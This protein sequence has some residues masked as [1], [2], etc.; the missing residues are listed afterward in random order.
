MK[1]K[2]RQWLNVSN[3]KLRYAIFLKEKRSH[4][5]HMNSSSLSIRKIAATSQSFLYKQ[6]KNERGREENEDLESLESRHPKYPTVK[7]C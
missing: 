5:V 7:A 6:Y 4:S 2:E 1:I 3:N